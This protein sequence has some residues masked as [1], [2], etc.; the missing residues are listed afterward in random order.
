ML[1]EVDMS[2]I[3]FSVSSARLPAVDFSEPVYIDEMVAIYA[4]PNV[5]PNITGFI[6]PY[7]SAVS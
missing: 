3:L 6:M 2:G 7:T 1:Q 5:E 4:R